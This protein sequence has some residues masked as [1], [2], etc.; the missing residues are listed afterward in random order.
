MHDASL[1]KVSDFQVD[2][3]TFLARSGL[4]LPD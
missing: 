3:T 4:S 1:G 2:Q